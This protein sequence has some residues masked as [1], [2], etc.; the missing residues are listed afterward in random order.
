[1]KGGKGLSLQSG[2]G[3]CCDLLVKEFLGFGPDRGVLPV[4]ESQERG[5]EIVYFFFP[6]L[7]GNQNIHFQG[8]QWWVVLTAECLRCLTGEEGGKVVNGNDRAGWLAL[9]TVDLHGGAIEGSRHSV[10][11]HGVE[12]RG[13]V[14]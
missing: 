6:Q 11:G 8:S 13:S 3:Q 9:E 7:L 5:E 4:V 14:L 1:M 12:R 2:R 10:N